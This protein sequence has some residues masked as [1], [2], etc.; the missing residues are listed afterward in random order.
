[1]KIKDALAR[2]HGESRPPDKIKYTRG[3]KESARAVLY[4]LHSAVTSMGL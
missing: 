4:R 3:E 1:M 2:K